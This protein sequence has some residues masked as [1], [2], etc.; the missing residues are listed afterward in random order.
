MF[1]LYMHICIN[2]IVA[3]ENYYLKKLTNYYKLKL[4]SLNIFSYIFELF[5]F[6]RI[7]IA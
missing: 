2:K 6:F 3:K 5:R 7:L 4:A 1:G